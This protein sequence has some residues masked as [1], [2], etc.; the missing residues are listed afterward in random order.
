MSFQLSPRLTLAELTLTS[1]VSA[2]LFRGATQFGWVS[3]LASEGRVNLASG[4]TFFF[5]INALATLARTT[6]GVARVTQCL[7][8]GF[9]AEIGIKEVKINSQ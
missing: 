2:Y 5:Q 6:S 3:Y 1:F 4:T 8:L 9:K 7:H